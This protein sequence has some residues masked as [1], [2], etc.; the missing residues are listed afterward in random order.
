MPSA[1]S[2]MDPKPCRLSTFTGMS[3]AQ[4]ARPATPF[5]LWVACAIVP[6]TCV[7]CPWSSAAT[8]FF[9]VKFHPGTQRVPARS[10]TRVK[11]AW[12]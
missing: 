4:G 7:P 3:E 12:S 2:D 10:L 1:T 6:A 11:G 5:P 9:P 8:A